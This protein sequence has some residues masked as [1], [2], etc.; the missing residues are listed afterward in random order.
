MGNRRHLVRLSVGVLVVG[1]PLSYLA[2]LGGA[3]RLSWLQLY[4]LVSIPPLVSAVL[5]GFA[6]VPSRSRPHSNRDDWLGGAVGSVSIWVLLAG[7]GLVGLS[8]LT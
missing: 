2:A 5:A 1:V 7:V 3:D 6:L 4:L 8:Y